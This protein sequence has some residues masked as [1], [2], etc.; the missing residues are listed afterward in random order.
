MQLDEGVHMETM[1]EHLVQP[2]LEMDKAQQIENRL[3]AANMASTHVV[4]EV[5]SIVDELKNMPGTFEG[6][7]WTTCKWNGNNKCE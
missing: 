6:R 5:F 4:Q 3:G 7:R 1:L 2:T